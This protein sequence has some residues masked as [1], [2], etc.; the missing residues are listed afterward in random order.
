MKW[1]NKGHEYDEIASKLC[2]ANADCLYYIW[3][4]GVFGKSFYN[5]FKEKI[6]ILG[7]VD[8]NKEKQTQMID[9]KRVY[10]PE[11]LA[12][13]RA[14]VLVSAGWTHDIFKELEKMGY[15]RNENCFHIDE[16]TS[17]FMMYKYNKVYVSDITYTIT[18]RCSLKCKNCNAFIPLYK[19]A[20][21]YLLKEIMD[22]FEK[23]FRWVD[24][25]NVL[26]LCGGDAMVNPQFANILREVGERYYPH[27]AGNIEVYSNA[28]IVPDEKILETMKKYDV[29]Y[30]FSDYTPYTAGKQKI[31][32]ITK[33]LQ[34]KEIKYDH[35]KF[36]K[37]CDCGYPQDSNGII[38][39]ENLEN[40]FKACDR[41][42]CH[43]LS[44]KGVMFCGMGL[45]A[46]RI[47]YCLA[48]KDDFFDIDSY[49]ENRRK[50]FLEFMLGYSTKGYLAYC[51]KCN[52]S[53]NVNHKLIESGE[54]MI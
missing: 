8:S 26:A 15:T 46:D 49:D 10:P 32:E 23:F 53:A 20:K 4:A 17:I 42:S 45:A 14:V 37:W 24:H 12:E 22:N 3:G 6:N 35:V 18:E 50:E 36:E 39:Q 16:F 34:K 21:N 54:Q 40:F 38:G 28:V 27:K 43:N 25:V 11:W 31:E 51:R 19:D 41:K 30:R 29:Y 33:L 5:L 7:F 9:G 2:S 48:D 13:H 47:G 1:T 44:E 52:G